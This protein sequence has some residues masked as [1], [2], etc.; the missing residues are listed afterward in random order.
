V[1]ADR[2][3]PHVPDRPPVD[4]AP[5][6]VGSALPPRLAAA[7]ALG[8]TGAAH[9]LGAACHRRSC[10]PR[11]Q[12][13]VAVSGDFP[14]IP[15]DCGAGA[16]AACSLTS[17]VVGVATTATLGGLVVP[18][19]AA[20]A[21]LR[22]SV[23]LRTYAT[24]V[25]VHESCGHDLCVGLYDLFFTAKLARPHVVVCQ[26]GCVGAAAPPLG[27]PRG[28]M[29]PTSCSIPRRRATARA[30]D[31]TDPRVG[32]PPPGRRR[33]AMLPV[34]RRGHRREHV[35]NGG[36]VSAAHVGRYLPTGTHKVSINVGEFVLVFPQMTVV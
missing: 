4:V 20:C 17:H 25:R 26:Q 11:F 19:T 13:R 9:P 21:P 1:G 8:A 12:L 22:T 31:V 35:Q 30:P 27:R 5:P 15:A 3:P 2:I 36:A 34:T 24:R 14:S 28:R 29:T 23:F 6:V 32:L 16:A 10:P 18:A 33:Q 7:H